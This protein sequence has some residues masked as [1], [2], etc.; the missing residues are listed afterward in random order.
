MTNA[1]D[2]TS[3]QRSFAH[4][5]LIDVHHHCVLPEY[6]EALVRAGAADPSKPLRTNSTP[7]AAI[8]AMA[9][10]GIA[11]AIVNPLSVAGVH[12]GNDDHARY[13]CESVTDA[14]A[15]FCQADTRK[16]GFFAPLPYPDIDGALKH[17][18]R[19]Y[20]AG[21]D[22]VILL[23][24]QNGAYVGDKRGEPLYEMLN[25][26][27]AVVFVH[28]NRP[29]FV[30][31]LPVQIWASIIEYPFETTRVAA[32]LIYNEYMRKY[33]R[34]KW[35]LAHA[36]G[37]LPYLSLRMHL[38]EEQDINRP[39][40]SE[41]VPEGALPYIGKFYYD[42]AIAGS[43]AALATLTSVARPD[44]I[45]YGS[46][47][48]YIY[49]SLVEEQQVTLEQALDKETFEAVESGSAAAL[50]PRFRGSRG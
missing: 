20:A 16:L 17:V 44:H 48:P 49:R 6:Q 34:I 13:L 42:T 45:M 11:G 21:A 28:P 25:E 10:F 23:S 15:K 2:A 7:Q 38:M 40:F 22:G 33:P 8:E 14:L 32:Y 47:W 26:R 37:T 24:N 4:L 19:A 43:A 5:K 30:D 29:P 18:E 9:S 12:H 36:G 35:I 31:E 27:G 39:A 41:R 1:A 50:F 46:D 3:G